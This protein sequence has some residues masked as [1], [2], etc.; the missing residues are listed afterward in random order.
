MS[1]RGP[2]PKQKVAAQESGV[3][4]GKATRMLAFVRKVIETA[5]VG[6]LTYDVTGQCVSANETAGTVL[7][8]S[9]EQ[10]LAQNFRRIESWRHSGALAAAEE[11]L[12]TGRG[13]QLE[14]HFATSFGRD[15]WLDLR[16][17]VFGANGD[18]HLLAVV[19]DRTE[20]KRAENAVQSAQ[21]FLAGVI[22]R[23]AD[24][25]FVK[26]DQRRL[27]LVN[28]ALC[29]MVGRSR[30]GL[31]GQDCDD[32]FPADQV[33][34]FR[35]MDAKVLDTG[36]ENVNEE[37]LSNLSTG[38]VLTIVT[39][40]TRYT[41][42]AGRKFLIGVVRDFTERKRADAALAE[43]EGRY[44]ALFDRSEDLVYLH[45]FE[46][47]FIDANDTA[48]KLLGYERSELASLS[49]ASLLT[50]DQ[51]PTAFESLRELVQTGTQQVP[52]TFTLR[53][54]S[55]G[56]VCVE[57]RAS[58]VWSGEK[59]VAI[60]AIGRN[61]TERRRAA[62][63]LE[64][65][66]MRYRRLFE[67]ARDGILILDAESGRIVDVNPFMVELT[68]YSHED[69]LDKHLWEIG[70]F[71][72]IAASKDSF[73]Q[74]QAEQYV[75]YDD[76]PL[77]TRDGRRIDVEFVS[78]VYLVDKRKVIQCNIRDIS[79]RMRA[80]AEHARLEGQL[81]AAQKMEAVGNLAGGI[82]HDF[83]NLLSV[84]LSYA[85]FAVDRMPAGDP[86]RGDLLEVKKAGE[87]A[88]SLTQQLL[89]FGRK[90]MLQPLPLDL[91]RILANM[92]D[93]LRR[94]IGEDV[95]LVLVEA[96]ELALVTADPGQ[97]EQVVMNLVVNARDAMPE[98]GRITIETSNVELDEA[99]AASHVAVSP[100]R[101]V[102]LAVTDTGRGMDEQIKARL[103]EP[104]F[105]TKERGK[106][107]GLGLSTVYG[108]VKQSGGNIHVYSELGKGTTFRVYLPR[109]LT[110]TTATTI[111]RPTLPRPTT[112]TETILVVDDEEVLRE[113]AR[114]ALE[115]AGYTVLVAGGG[116][117]ALHIARR[118]R[119][120]IHLLLTDVVMPQVNGARLAEQLLRM[121]PTVQVLYMSGYTGDAVIQRGVLAAGTHFLSK[122][123]TA[124]EL[125]WRVREVLDGG[126]ARVADGPPP[127]GA[128]DDETMKQPL[129][130]DALR[131]LPLGVL[132]KLRRAVIA[133]RHDE[134]VELVEA[135]RLTRPELATGLRRMADVFDHDGLQ[136]F[137]GR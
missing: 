34:V 43:S 58:V 82:A 41:D 77:N 69:F 74:L 37:S 135:I 102:L 78:N 62:E 23:I 4:G 132:D 136:S 10:L 54:K 1:V 70:P 16:L 44:R 24:P 11:T 31:L 57:T 29:T 111:R 93:M 18:R 84:I 105:T 115:A 131:A 127:A 108:I 68:G 60:Q 55:G 49:F 5:P 85:G 95:E 8:A 39:R 83:N 71:R 14:T 81:R 6:I 40:K 130:Q 51:L 61:I 129:D 101:Y 73:A 121:R 59:P 25:I 46:G 65:S 19:T 118:H 79:D 28:D 110:A 133:A 116:V 48:L 7:G 13:R 50:E 126:V 134:I 27:V 38:E 2:I 91:N 15:A 53:T 47:R 112:G 21:A 20:R 128:P 89:A 36:E 66:E 87:R 56:Q 97:V 103:F 117:E 67:A 22:D 88:A 92:V 107:T 30:E 32:A 120:R 33:A 104:F 75:R 45:D 90:Q 119:G 113:V 52:T 98:G 123:F 86:I 9:V 94:I 125:T 17:E 99:Y 124:L 137:L 122:P 106:G 72:D 35:A 64:A 80:E 76:L 3:A 114:R 100:G 109:E 26:D 42:P 96:P 12:A 63:V